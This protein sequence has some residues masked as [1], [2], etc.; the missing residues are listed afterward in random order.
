MFRNVIWKETFSTGDIKK[1]NKKIF[2]ANWKMYLND[3]ESKEFMSRIASNKEFFSEFNIMIFPN[4][5]Y[6]SINP[7][8]LF[9]RNMLVVFFAFPK[10]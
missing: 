6:L 3:N 4:H 5:L 9:A 2:A 1:M 7:F 10:F 8:L